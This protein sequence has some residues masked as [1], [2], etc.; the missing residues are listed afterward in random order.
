MAELDANQS[1]NYYWQNAKFKNVAFSGGLISQFINDKGYVTSSVAV[2]ASY[3]FTASY[4]K[5]AQTASY[6]SGSIS[7]AVSSSFASTASYVLNAVSA[8]YTLNTISASYATTASYVKTAQTASYIQT[9]QTASYVLN[10]QSASYVETAQTAS[11]IQIAQTAS[12]VLNAVSA[13]YSQTASYVQTAQT[14]SYVQTAQTASYILNAISASYTSTASYVLNAISASY[15]PDTTFPYTG[16]ALISGSLTVTGSLQVGTPSQTGVATELA[17]FKATDSSTFLQI[18]NY[19][20]NAG[21]FVPTIR[22][23]HSASSTSPGLQLIAQIGTDGSTNTNPAMSFMVMSQSAAVGPIKNRTLFTWENNSTSSMALSTVGLVIGN[24]LTKASASLH[25]NNTSSFNSFLVEDDTTP[26]STPFVI[27]SIGRVGIGKL[28]PSASLDI[29]GSVLITGSL[30]VSLGITGSLQGTATTSSFVNP[31]TQSVSINGNL[32]LGTIT[33]T[34]STENSLNVYPPIPTSGT[35]EG[36]QILLAA[37]GSPYTSASMLDNYQNQFRILKGTNTGGSDG[38]VLSINLQTLGTKFEG[39]VT[40]SAYSGLPND[41][42]YVTRNTN[43]TIGSGNWANQDIIFNNSVVSKGISYNTGTGLASLTAGKV[44]RITARLAWS[45]ASTYLFQYSCYDSS[46]SQLGPTIEIVQ[47]TNA[48]NNISD[49]TLEFIYA[50]GSNINIKIRTTNS[51]SALSG[52]YIRGDLNT[53]LIIQ[54][55]A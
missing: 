4:V 47:S 7:N 5:N 35:G 2:S 49:G 27:D 8:S 6:I 3:A 17:R 28:S 24:G 51:T 1:Y 53:Q 42:L 29:T 26:D 38:G 33:S 13:S 45:A 20:T 52:E 44:Y 39:A 19:G 21:V 16:S 46:N 50:P 30:N 23:L 11:Y 40:A 43:Q 41:Y 12:Y 25:I 14:A 32:T 10:A 34:P 22:T 54:Q 36:G 55:I 18:I 9:A 48:S 15:A 31:L 37:S